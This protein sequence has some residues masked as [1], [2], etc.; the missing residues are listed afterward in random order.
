MLEHRFVTTIDIR[1]YQF[2]NNEWI[3][4]VQVLQYEGFT[5]SLVSRAMGGGGV[6]TCH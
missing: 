6:S 1:A 2:R 3:L 5:G 4:L